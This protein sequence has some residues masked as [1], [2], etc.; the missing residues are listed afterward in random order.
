M[1]FNTFC[2]VCLKIAHVVEWVILQTPHTRETKIVE[3]PARQQ[4][5]DHHIQIMINDSFTT[6]SYQ[7]QLIGFITLIHVSILIMPFMPLTLLL[8]T[9]NAT[10]MTTQQTHKSNYTYKFHNKTNNSMFSA[11]TLSFQGS[12]S[13]RSSKH[14]LVSID[15]IKHFWAKEE[16]GTALGRSQRA[17]MK[18]KLHHISSVNEVMEVV[19]AGEND[20]SIQDP[21]CNV[22]DDDLIEL[23]TNSLY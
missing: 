6:E 4:Q 22:T 8:A 11:G 16:R 20:S 15:T 14:L 1:G 13:I 3:I 10:N 17:N 23:L 5:L 12:L 18:I 19:I 9:W 7:G 21:V 2:T